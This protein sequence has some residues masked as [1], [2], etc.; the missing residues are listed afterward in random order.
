MD[1][2]YPRGCVQGGLSKLKSW[3]YLPQDLWHVKDRLLY[4]QLIHGAAASDFS[5]ALLQVQPAAPG[6]AVLRPP[7][8]V[9]TVQSAAPVEVAQLK[10]QVDVEVEQLVLGAEADSHA[11]DLSSSIQA[12]LPNL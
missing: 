7:L 10:L 11:Q 8:K 4:G 5:Q 1:K 9:L 2:A 6:P 12:I 3:Q